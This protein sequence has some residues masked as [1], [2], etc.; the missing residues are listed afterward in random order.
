MWLAAVQQ[1]WQKTDV[2]GS[3]AQQHVVNPTGV[4]IYVAL[5]CPQTLLMVAL[6]VLRCN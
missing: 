3:L 2:A 1:W 5:S 4:Y 6:G